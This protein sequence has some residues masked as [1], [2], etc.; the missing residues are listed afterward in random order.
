MRLVFPTDLLRLLPEIRKLLSQRTGGAQVE[1]IFPRQGIIKE[2][3]SHMREQPERE[4]GRGGYSRMA[5]TFSKI[6][7][8]KTHI[9]VAERTKIRVLPHS[10]YV[11]SLGG[12]GL[13]GT[14]H[15]NV[16]YSCL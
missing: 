10:P 8:T 5:E 3:V 6:L 4:E 12:T 1:D 11:T 9:F 16:H 13:S 2:W 7:N 14:R 15:G